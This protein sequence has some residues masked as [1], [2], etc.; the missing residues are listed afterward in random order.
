VIS[1]LLQTDAMY[2]GVAH[3]AGD[4][5]VIPRSPRGEEWLALEVALTALHHD[6]DLAGR[7]LE[8]AA[9][10]TTSAPV[11]YDDI[12]H[13]MDVAVRVGFPS[14]AITEPSGLSWRPTL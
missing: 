9:A 1:L 6:A 4:A 8:V 2:L 13:A 11:T 14:V 12:I 3:L 5:V 7:P 10:S